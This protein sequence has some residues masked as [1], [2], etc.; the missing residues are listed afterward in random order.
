MNG[1]YKSKV[2]KYLEILLESKNEGTYI[3]R[4]QSC[5]KWDLQSG[6][7]RRLD[8]A[9][10]KKKSD[11]I[12]YHQHLIENAK[13][14]GY[15]KNDSA[16]NSLSDLEI[17]AEIQH[18]GGATCLTD[19]T[20]NF[21]VALWFATKETKVDTEE[22]VLNEKKQIIYDADGNKVLTT[23][24]K[25]FALN[26]DN[27]ENL[28]KIYP[29]RE[30]R[31]TDN[32]TNLLNKRVQYN[33]LT[34]TIDSRFWVWKP[35][36]LNNR[37]ISQDSIFM[38]GLPKLKG[39]LKYKEIYIPFGDKIEL[40]KE[41]QIYFNLCPETVFD[42]ITGFSFEANNAEKPISTLIFENKTCKQK[43]KS[44]FK[45]GEYKTAIEYYDRAI[46]CKKGIEEKC[47]QNCNN[48]LALLYFGR[49]N[50]FLQMDKEHKSLIA[51]CDFDTAIYL[52]LLESNIDN[53]TYYGSLRKK[54]EI[55]YN[56]KNYKE[57]LVLCEKI[58]EKHKNS[59]DNIKGFYFSLLE[60]SVIDE[61]KETF[62]RAIK[63][64]KNEPMF[65]RNNGLLLLNFFTSINQRIDHIK[66]QRIIDS[67]LDKIDT[68]DAGLFWEFEDIKTW[69][70][71]KK[72]NDSD[73][74]INTQMTINIQSELLEK[75]LNK[76][77]N[78]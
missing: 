21:L 23:H 42:D 61:N 73:L 31:E 6:A 29:I 30:I 15:D 38:F 5:A 77:A 14:F 12:L 66:Y 60:L 9:N 51:F 53:Y 52:N 59:F 58:I 4:G 20:T 67:I 63:F 48:A 19:F 49:G 43:A 35:Q 1:S 32:I 8:K 72:N 22:E 25:I 74:L 75:Q 16:I 45:R 27:I 18:H 78:N 71:D 17:L 54:L 64:I 47:N 3:Y 56:L 11:F 26:L 13:D 7:Q 62:N 46:K 34:K 28:E 41:L 65:S 40:Q 55:L 10:K 39:N 24:G 50:S 36:K 37:I 44:C 68:F 76:N 2:A 33:D 57:A 69:I 70:N